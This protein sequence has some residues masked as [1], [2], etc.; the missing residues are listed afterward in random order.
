MS[1]K[2]VLHVLGTGFG[3]LIL[4]LAA[5]AYLGFQKTV[6]IQSNAAALV[7]AQLLD[8]N[9]LDALDRE[10]RRMSDVMF[11]IFLRGS[12]RPLDGGAVLREVESG[13]A[14]I[15]RLAKLSAD[16]AALWEQL[17]QASREFAGAVRESLAQ[18]P[19][20]IGEIEELL[21]RH[22]RFVRL[23]G[24]LIKAGSEREARVEAAIEAQSRELA[25][26]SGWLLAGCFL[27]AVACA[28]LALKVT[29]DAFR[30]VEIQ[31]AEL[32][33]VS[34]HMLQGQET[35]ARRFS[36]EMH[37]ELGQSL[38]GLKATLSMITPE[39]FVARRAEYTRLL[40][41]AIHNV[42]ELSQLLRPVIL[43]DLGLDAGLRWL[44]ERFQQRTGIETEYDSNLEG[45]L[46]EETE[47]QL[48]RIAQESLT[49]VARHSG[50]TLVRASLRVDG[51]TVRLLVEDNG[52]GLPPEKPSSKPSLGMIGMRARA[53]QVRGSLKVGVS[54]LGG[55][56]IEVVA[57]C[58]RPDHDAEP[59]D[60]NLARR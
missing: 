23:A 20:T 16:D 4:L 31:G 2:Q 10:Q 57:P 30:R 47:T 35:A 52:G 36:H 51:A 17:T 28:L 9:L 39:E 58:W 14:E 49:N 21:A 15:E 29:S 60:E 12:G 38:T 1:R 3:L 40:E 18:P 42:R 5:V 59:K 43:D 55:V 7:R 37:D 22:N 33:R 26:R 54:D 32:A 27:L 19:A 13:A 50:A 56:K 41:E 53:S 6:E 8:R 48:F 46:A 11:R 45:R 34:W 24:D 25:G 44:L